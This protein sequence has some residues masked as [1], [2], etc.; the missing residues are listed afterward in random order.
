[1]LSIG[2]KI[3]L[4]REIG[5]FPFRMGTIFTVEDFYKDDSIIIKN[6]LGIGIMTCDELEKYFEIASKSKWTDWIIKYK[7]SVTFSE[8]NY[9]K[10]VDFKYRHNCKI[11]EIIK[12][13]IKVRAYCHKD[14]EFDLEKGI[15]VALAKFEI[16]KEENK[17][18]KLSSDLIYSEKELEKKKRRYKEKY[19]KEENT[20]G[21]IHKL[22][23]LYI[24]DTK[25]K[26]STKS[27]DL[28]VIPSELLEKGDIFDYSSDP[29]NI[30]I[31]NTDSDDAYQ[32]QWIEVNDKDKKLLICDR[33]ILSKISWDDLNAQGLVEGK[34]ITIDNKKYK[35]RLL[36]GGSSVRNDGDWY[37]G[38]SPTDNEWDRIIVNEGK[39]N[40]LPV[41]S[42]KDLDKALD[43]TDYST[44]HNKM[45]NWAGVY[46]WCKETYSGNSNSSVFRGYDS[47][48]YFIYG[49][50][51]IRHSFIGWRPVLEVLE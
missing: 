3:R 29:K 51:D 37:S 7:Y 18:K 4:V 17:V 41:P 35:I 50:R 26:R 13:G 14:D 42:N 32:L 19:C 28:K 46:S 9:N 49:D 16:K 47:A 8:T 12:D 30:E 22:G 5:K 39:L 15:E 40:G 38:G 43:S 23:T 45:W 1:M 27:W 11:V 25:I 31:R 20:N 34:I 21:T 44:V 36:T 10:E 2:T 48:R 6:R 33:N 24:G